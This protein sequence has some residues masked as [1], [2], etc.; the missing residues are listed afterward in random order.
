MDKDYLKEKL[1]SI[2]CEMNY[3]WTGELVTFGGA[4]SFSIIENKNIWIYFCIAA[5]I[6]IG[7]L[8]LNAFTIRRIE[9]KDIISELKKE[10]I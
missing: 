1:N 5:G 4:F 2:R 9:I 7:L 6:I 8:F 10:V 3:L